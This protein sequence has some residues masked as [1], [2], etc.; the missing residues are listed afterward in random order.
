MSDPDNPSPGDVG[1]SISRRGEDV[2]DQEGKEAGRKDT[3]PQGESGRP[4]GTSDSRDATG[5]NPQ[6]PIDGGPAQGGQG[7]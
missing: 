5:V 7:G 1:E 4:A 6:E 2:A 3:G